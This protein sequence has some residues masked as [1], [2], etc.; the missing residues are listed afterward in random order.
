MPWQP[1]SACRSPVARPRATTS[2]VRIG[3]QAAPHTDADWRKSLDVWGQ[4]YRDNPAD[5]EAAINYAKALRATEQR[6]QAVAVL[7][8]ASMRNPHDMPLLGAYG[9]AL[10]DAGDYQQALDVLDRAHTPDKPDWRILNAQGAVLDQIG[11]HAEARQHYSAA[12]KI[13]PGEPSV[14]SNLGLSYALTKDLKQ[15][16]GDAA[17]RHGAAER[18][19]EGAAESRAGGRPAGP[20]RRSGEDRLAPICRRARPPPMSLICARCWRSKAT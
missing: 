17:P 3:S 15:R 12:L 19:A 1:C 2:P 10:A 4:R 16:R 13:V 6:A 9:R 18:R 20:L 11:R 7:E 8:Q 14:L 5:A